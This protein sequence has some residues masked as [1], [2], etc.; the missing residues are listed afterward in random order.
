MTRRPIPGSER[1]CGGI[2]T[3]DPDLGADHS[4]R[5]TCRCGLPGVAG[6]AHHQPVVVPEQAVVASWYEVEE[7]EG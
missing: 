1:I 3:P 2:F 6:D 7:G 5:L 4:G